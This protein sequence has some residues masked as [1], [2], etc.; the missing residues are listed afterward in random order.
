MNRLKLVLL[1]LSPFFLMSQSQRTVLMEEFTQASCP[2]CETSTPPLNARLA[3]N[4]DKVVQIRYQVFWPGTDPMNEDNPREVEDRRIFYDVTSV[5][6]V[7]LDGR[8]TN[9]VLSNLLPQTAIN[10]AYA[11]TAPVLLE[12]D[13]E[14]AADLKT[15]TINAK[16]FNEG[17]N[18]FSNPSARLRIAIIEEVIEWDEPPGSTSITDF[19]AVFKGFVGGSAG[20]SIPDIPGSNFT[21]YNWTNL[22]IPKTMYNSNSVSLVAFIQ[23]DMTKEI[24]NAAATEPQVQPGPYTDISI[25]DFSRNSTGNLCNPV[26]TSNISFTNNSNTPAT[27]LQ[28]TVDI[29]GQDEINIPIGG[30]LD[31]GESYTY[32]HELDDLP[33]GVS[34]VN[35]S[36]GSDVLDLNSNN[37]S[38]PNLAFFRISEEVT[39]DLDDDFEDL[40]AFNSKY[41]IDM[42]NMIY[43]ITPTQ[44]AGER[45]GAYEMSDNSV[46][47][48][49]WEWNPQKL[50]RYGFM[51]PVRK[52]DIPCG[53]GNFIFDHAYAQFQPTTDDELAIEVSQCGE[54]YT[55]IWKQK[56][57]E[58]AT[59]PISVDLFSP[60]SSQWR[61]NNIDL[62]LYEGQTVHLRFKMT[63]DFGNLLFLDNIGVTLSQTQTDS[64]TFYRDRDNDGYG[65]PNESISS[66]KEADG[67]VTDNTDCDDYDCTS[68][69]GAPELCDW[70][71]NNCNGEIDEGLN[72]IT[73][74]LDNDNDGYGDSNYQRTD[75]TQPNSYVPQA[76]DCNDND[77]DINPSS[78]EICDGLDNNCDYNIDEDL[79][80][81][82]YYQD[83]D[84]DGF[85][86]PEVSV[87]DCKAVFG[88]VTNNLDCNDWDEFTYP[89]AA[90]VCDYQDNNCDGTIDEGLDF[91]TYY[92][93]N[94]N[95]GY[96]DINDQSLHCSMPNNGYVVQ[97]GDCNDNDPNINP[98]AS[99][100]CDGVD[101]NCDGTIDE[102]LN[103]ITYYL[104][105]D[106]DGYGD[107]N[108]Q[109]TDCT[110][111]NSYVPQAG[112]CNDNDPNINPSSS[113]ICDGLDNNCDNNIDED[114][115]QLTYYQ[116]LDQDGFGNPEVSVIDC[117]AVDGYV[118]NNTDCDDI[119]QFTYPDAPELCDYLDNNCDGMI[120][121]GL[122]F[123]T[124]YL[125]ND[126]D[127][128]GDINSQRTDC[129]QLNSYVT[130]A[131]DC[132]DNDPNI[133]P[134]M[135]ESCNSTDDNCDGNIDEGLV[136]VTYYSD[137]DMDG[138]GDDTTGFEDCLQPP[139]TTTEGGDC[140]DS[141]PNIYP[142]AE[143]IVNNGI[144]E[145]CDGMD[146][147]SAVQELGGQS[148]SIFPNPFTTAVTVQSN[149]AGLTYSVFSIN[150]KTIIAHQKLNGDI[151]L[152]ELDS[153]MYLLQIKTA[154]GSDSI[155]ELIIKS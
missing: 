72:Y 119:D 114:L 13:H 49:F 19:E 35:Y 69:P 10:S 44:L 105:N 140:D 20:H 134:D 118:T 139:N 14:M 57:S 116:D 95:D 46:V 106:N 32:Q 115:T 111:P 85:G 82:T 136:F 76:G 154:S 68:Y 86:N 70:L 65:D 81:L 50:S 58:L 5:P 120:D 54:K 91:I 11:K 109:R 30:S 143:E 96:G 28:L 12:L 39:D 80:Q 144:D 83:L 9:G 126:N 104:D 75:C 16:I 152:S 2:P 48:N 43:P 128:Y 125:D 74:Y 63:S 79:T 89:G 132:N 38:S 29:S 7:M 112:D 67:Y 37:H 97:A 36:I 88:Y 101:N 135:E 149:H 62:S 155:I 45:A 26:Y 15:M 55:T 6:Y 41:A 71:D 148:V 138:Y 129:I 21:S 59:S 34:I 56:G 53:G 17:N 23:D 78:S 33:I 133:N 4:E 61:T 141:N 40:E 66:C 110:Q 100:T 87:I 123:I 131:G 124:Y 122:N 137:M 92:H 130:Q 147:T 150:G 102:G 60:T 127:G 93:D 22:K 51:M 142:G 146:L 1:V 107:S 117:K 31:S 90:E 108:S 47:V 99:E 24:L 94:D 98:E 8:R 18:L 77:P 103:S 27:N 64:Q 25:E 52:I 145:D 84:Q 73:Y 153:G 121:E 42:I 151:D 113:E 3:E